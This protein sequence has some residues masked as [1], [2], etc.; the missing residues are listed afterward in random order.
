MYEAEGRHRNATK[1]D[2]SSGSASR[3]RGVCEYIASKSLLLSCNSNKQVMS[4]RFICHQMIIKR[5]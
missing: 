3:R 4:G 2:I 5:A 1:D